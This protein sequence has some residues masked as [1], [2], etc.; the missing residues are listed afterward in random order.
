MV[1]F[2]SLGI[3]IDDMFIFVYTLVSPTFGSLVSLVVAL[4]LK[5]V[6][7]GKVITSES[8]TRSN[9]GSSV[10]YVSKTQR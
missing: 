3:G 6:Y 8:A 9:P 10:G 4:D 7:R 1:P 5:H 2:L